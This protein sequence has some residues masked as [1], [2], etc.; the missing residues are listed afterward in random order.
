MISS[1]GQGSSRVGFCGVSG[2]VS[3]FPEFGRVAKCGSGW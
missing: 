2:F 3:L 1:L